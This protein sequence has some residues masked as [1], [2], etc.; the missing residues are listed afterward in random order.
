MR[1]GV[2]VA[3]GLA[4]G[5]ILDAMVGDP[6]RWHP[7]AGFGQAAQSIE[8]HTYRDIRAA[9]A[10]HVGLLVGGAI[11]LGV[12]FDRIARTPVAQATLVAA[13]TWAVLGAR[14]LTREATRI[15][16]DLHR[17][18]LE[19]AR[20]HVGRIVSRDPSELDATEIARATAE[21]V[22]ENTSDAVVA[23]LF[24]GAVAGVPGLLGYR[25]VNT[26]DAMIGYRTERYN[27]FGWAAA[28]ADDAA[29]WIPARLTAVLVAAVA[30]SMG[31]DPRTALRAVFAHARRHPSP[32]GGVAEAAFAGALG[33]RLGG[34]NTY[35]G[36]TEDRG[37]LGFGAAPEGSDIART[38]TLAHRT[39]LA[40]ALLTSVLA[41]LRWRRGFPDQRRQGRGRFLP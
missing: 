34:V 8:R 28:R 27:R 41:L 40:A 39:G 24:W 38:T 33:L 20:Q 7:V 25:A 14:S 30:P 5:F 35:D 16:D 37:H 12:A 11:G 13:A 21:S 26:L 19:A 4:A 15:A 32:N 2:A 29:N 31:G 10:A 1:R 23:P 3:A 6:R 17:Q 18:D 36:V 22:A 9:G